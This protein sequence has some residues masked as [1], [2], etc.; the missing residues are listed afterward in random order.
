MTN[1]KIKSYKINMSAIDKKIAKWAEE[2]I[3]IDKDMIPLT[4]QKQ[5]KLERKW[6]RE[7]TRIEK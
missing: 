1:P 6:W 2:G 4:R 7:D 5:R 3:H